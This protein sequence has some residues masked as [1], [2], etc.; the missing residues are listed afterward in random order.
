M[1]PGIDAGFGWFGAEE[2]SPPT[3]Y[4]GAR[5]RVI[6]EWGCPSALLVFGKL[7][8]LAGDCENFADVVLISVLVGPGLALG[9]AG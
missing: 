1:I 7:D 9:E 6:S 3:P 5:E 4:P 8:S 2:P